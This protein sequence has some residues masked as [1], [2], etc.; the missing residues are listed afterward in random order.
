MLSAFNIDDF[1]HKIISINILV[2]TLNLNYR[3]EKYSN[4]INSLVNGK[5]FERKK[6]NR[7]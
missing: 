2:L 1:N 6:G 7:L 4:H 3:H 5:L